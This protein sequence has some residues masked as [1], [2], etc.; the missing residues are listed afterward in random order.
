M[1]DGKEGNGYRN[2]PSNP[3]SAKVKGCSKLNFRR[4]AETSCNNVIDTISEGTIVMVIDKGYGDWTLI[5]YKDKNGY[6]MSKFLED[7]D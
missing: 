7:I 3:S 4:T 1:F 2:P 6:V 5:S